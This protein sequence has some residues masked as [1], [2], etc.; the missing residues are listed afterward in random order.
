M[1]ESLTCILPTLR[2]FSALLSRS[3]VGGFM[4]DGKFC[5]ICAALVGSL[6]ACVSTDDQAPPS[7]AETV[8]S[9]PQPTSTN[10]VAYRLSPVIASTGSI[11]ALKVEMS[12]TGQPGGS[13]LIRLPERFAGGPDLVPNFTD[14][15]AS[16]GTLAPG[17]RPGQWLVRAP[18]GARVSFSYLVHSGIDHEPS[19]TDEQPFTP[20]IRGDWF[21]LFGQT[22]WA[23]PQVAGDTPT[24]FA[25]TGPVGIVIAS[26]LEHFP[27]TGGLLGSGAGMSGSTILGGRDVRVLRD[28]PIRLA[29]HGR[30]ALSDQELLTIASRVI[31]HQRAFVGEPLDQPYLV[32]IAEVTAEPGVRGAIGGTGQGDAYSIVMT[33]DAPRSQLL[34]IFAH[35]TF[36]SWGFG[37]T[38]DA[39]LWI[40]EGFTDYYGTA[41][42]LR[43]GLMTL[44][45]FAEVWNDRLVAYAASP[46]RARKNAEMSDRWA[47][48]DV[49]HM[50]YLRGA[51]IAAVW[52]RRLRNASDGKTSLDEVMMQQHRRASDDPTVKALDML[53]E[54]TAAARVD[55]S[56]DLVAHIDG[57]QPIILNADA[58]GPCFRV[59]TVEI[60]TYDRGFDMEASVK[61]GMTAAGVREGG[62]AHA[63]GLRNGMRLVEVIGGKRDD[64]TQ[65]AV[66]IVEA[67]D[68]RQTLRWLPAGQGRLTVQQLVRVAGSPSDAAACSLD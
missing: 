47:D 41:T 36:H 21:Y 35:E 10:V 32:N 4:L 31:Q 17:E 37:Q 42:A 6:G 67:N 9:A 44:D 13:N 28:G 50:Q 52:D 24:T 59:T 5:A 38:T 49:E 8:R 27:A 23:R 26:D 57:G 22:I 7:A 64:S 12:F 18:A 16:G 39:E 55:I 25:W 58:F 62:P 63:A 54:L 68:Q 51:I 40:H 53:R 61:A 46:A 45:E 15:T 29:L 14:I 65:E 19:T 60:P 11:D 48:P 3:G 1:A 2:L 43:A 34:S 66:W 33:R 30:V 56:A 20:W